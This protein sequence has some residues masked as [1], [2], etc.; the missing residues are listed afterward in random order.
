MHV[1]VDIKALQKTFAALP[2]STRTKALT[3]ALVAG[4]EVVRRA[5]IDNI[6]AIA[7]DEVTGTLARSIVV[8]R[9]KQSK[10]RLRVGVQIRKNARHPTKRDRNGAVRVALY[11]A[12][13]EYGKANQKPR[14]W[15]RK[16]KTEKEFQ[17]ISVVR[18][19]A[20]RRLDAAVEDAKR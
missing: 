14:P 10:G 9:Y 4:A 15:I 13:L 19:E 16:A 6:K 20:Y 8:R 12:V 1:S 11:G 17:A 18:N 7:K 5:A 2:R 3:P